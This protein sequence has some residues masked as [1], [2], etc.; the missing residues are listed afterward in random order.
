MADYGTDSE[1]DR[2]AE[3]LARVT[4]ER[5]KVKES[6]ES[7]KRR[8]EKT[9]DESTMAPTYATTTLEERE[10]GEGDG[11]SRQNQPIFQKGVG[12]Q[13]G[14]MRGNPT[15]IT[16]DTPQGDVTEQSTVLKND[17]DTSQPPPQMEAIDDMTVERSVAR[18]ALIPSLLNPLGVN[19]NAIVTRRATRMMGE[20]NP[21][22]DPEEDV[23][24]IDEGVASQEEGMN[25]TVGT[26]EGVARTFDNPLT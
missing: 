9:R 11:F 21:T 13:W 22:N 19:R 24:I 1:D 23:A 10:I 17:E 7:K 26:V 20:A 5:R 15:T 3:R 8:T 16:V 4:K 2:R 6:K 14:E 12:G 18:T 25:P